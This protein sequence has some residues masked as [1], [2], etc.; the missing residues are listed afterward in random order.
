MHGHAGGRAL[1]TC[2]TAEA[3]TPSSPRVHGH[4]IAQCRA[5]NDTRWPSS[6]RN[7]LACTATLSRTPTTQA[8]EVNAP[9]SATSQA[10]TERALPSA[11]GL[12]ASKQRASH[13]SGGGS[14]KSE[15][16]PR[17]TRLW[18]S[19]GDK[20]RGYHTPR[21]L[22]LT[23][24][25]ESEPPIECRRLKP[26]DPRRHSP[27]GNAAWESHARRGVVVDA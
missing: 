24:P 14:C 8:A 17:R 5:T 10:T 25:V 16:A 7:L 27:T 12:C 22:S 1:K 26:P 3:K 11:R 18:L 6:P 23:A 21:T 4:S 20:P 13:G 2:R 19:A 15:R 9:S